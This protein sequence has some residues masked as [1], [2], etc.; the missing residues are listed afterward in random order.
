MIRFGDY[1]TYIVHE[2][3]HLVLP[4][5]IQ[6][7]V[8]LAIPTL[9]LI[10]ITVW[11]PLWLNYV[12]SK[13]YLNLKYSVFEIKLPKE[14]FK[15]PQAMELFLHALHNTSDGNFFKRFWGGES[16]PWYSLELA[17]IGG[18][19]KFY[20]WGEDGR[21]IGLM[22]ALYAQFPGIEVR[23]VEDY[24][25]NTFYN[26][27][28]DKY[29]CAEFTLNSDKPFPIKTY[30]DWGL[31]KDPKEEFKVDPLV[32]GLEFLAS[33]AP[34]QQVWIQLI[35]RAHKKEQIK[36]GF[37]FK[38]H[39]KWK[40][41]TEAAINEIMKR[42]PKTRKVL[43][44]DKETGKDKPGDSYILP[45]LS[46]VEKEQVAALSKKITKLPFDVCA[47]VM[48]IATKK[49]FDTPFGIGGL[50][51]FFKAFNTEH[52]NG[53]KPNGD[54]W[55]PYLD[56]PWKDYRDIRRNRYTN[57]C[58]LQYK[59]R[60]TY[61]PPYVGTNLV[62]NTEEVATIYHFPGSVAATPTL[63]RVPSKKGEAPANLPV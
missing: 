7:V 55:T 34:G 35:I 12:R 48:Y 16:R 39:D 25:K 38:P 21:K 29:W 54:K 61:F 23:Q 26:P 42:D 11:W 56:A 33:V 53:F 40:D 58:L 3:Q 5:V 20:M 44:K 51:S 43:E 62:L 30:I 45:S 6:N 18:Q 57:E 63:E 19:V 10:L 1:S 31:D 9:A 27:V 41:D 17:S 60:A 50:I 59:M 32:P 37:F 24:T 47:R 22:S 49:T 36:P 15:S 14:T 52:L 8:F 4:S 2:F 13:R 46:D 28:T